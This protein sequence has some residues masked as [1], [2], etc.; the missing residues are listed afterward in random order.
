MARHLN[1]RLGA[2]S[3]EHRDTAH[4]GDSSGG[5]WDLS[6][7]PVAEH[8]PLD[9]IETRT[10][11]SRVIFER[12]GRA[13]EGELARLLRERSHGVRNV[14]HRQ[15]EERSSDDGADLIFIEFRVVRDGLGDPV[16]ELRAPALKAGLS[17]LG[18]RSHVRCSLRI[19]G[20]VFPQLLARTH[21]PRSG[22]TCSFMPSALPEPTAS[23][24]Q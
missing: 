12:Y 14:D 19:I 4:R 9:L 18:G 17:S 15:D 5:C 22:R 1:R 11:G 7:A 3:R 24:P 20:W 2:A 6:A 10:F 13:R 23:S 21:T 8:V 16:R